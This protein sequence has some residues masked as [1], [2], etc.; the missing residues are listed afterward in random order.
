MGGTFQ[1]KGRACEMRPENAWPIGET[2]KR[3]RSPLSGNH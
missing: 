1:A 3:S 2:E